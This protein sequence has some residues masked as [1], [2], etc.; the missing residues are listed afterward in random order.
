MRGTRWQTVIMITSPSKHD[1]GL[2][3]CLLVLLPAS[4]NTMRGS[5]YGRNT[6][7]TKAWQATMKLN[8]GLHLSANG[9]Q[10]QDL[11]G[12]PLPDP[13]NIPSVQS[14]M[15]ILN[16]VQAR[17]NK[18]LLEM[19]L[20]GHSFHS[21]HNNRD[22]SSF[23]VNHNLPIA[24]SIIR[25]AV[26]ARTN[27]LPTGETLQLDNPNQN[28]Y[29]PLCTLSP[30]LDSLVHRLNHCPSK[31]SKGKLSFSVRKFTKLSFSVISC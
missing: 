23:I 8:I 28:R 1:R 3:R 4:G 13:F 26:S 18:K 20:R 14:Q 2:C 12:D 22:A 17:W 5:R 30:T 7:A 15:S 16:I 6:F 29:C 24:D 19:S 31:F 9:F 10:L 21:L 27:F 25:F 11:E